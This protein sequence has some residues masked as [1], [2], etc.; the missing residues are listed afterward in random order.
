M[1]DTEAVDRLLAALRRR[2]ESPRDA[3]PELRAELQ[4]ML[5][6]WPKPGTDPPSI[7][8]EPARLP[9]CDHLDH[10]LAQGLT[11]PEAALARAIAAIAPGLRWTYGYPPDPRW[12]ALGSNVAFTQ[13]VGARGLRPSP[14]LHLGLTLIAPETRYPA[15]RHPAVETYL[16]LSGTAVWQAGDAAAAPRSP[17]SLIFH[18]SGIPHAMATE[19]EP[20]LALFSWRGDLQSPSVYVEM[21]S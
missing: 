16:V 12:P 15:H 10:A 19:A 9:A 11:G 8:V 17:G 4:R 18:P 1:I 6:A 20:L 13:I 3:S 5:D 2:Y 7:M 14:K 21:P